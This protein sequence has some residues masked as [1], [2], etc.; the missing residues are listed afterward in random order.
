[1]NPKALF[2]G[3]AFLAAFC[4]AGTAISISYRSVIGIILT[5]LALCAV[6]GFGFSLKKKFREAGKL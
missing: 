1:M 5:L 4:M 3:L 2:L 6:M